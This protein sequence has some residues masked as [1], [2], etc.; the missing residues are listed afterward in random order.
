MPGSFRTI[1]IF[2]QF[3]SCFQV[4]G[5][6][7]VP[8]IGLYIYQQTEEFSYS[9]FSFLGYYRVDFKCCHYIC[10]INQSIVTNKQV[11]THG[12]AKADDVISEIAE[13]WENDNLK[14]DEAIDK[15]IRMH[16]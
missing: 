7:Y 16:L 12:I 11:E 8:A 1:F 13:I 3:V 2:Q 5:S 15:W 6:G 4:E 9:L 10:V 14:Q